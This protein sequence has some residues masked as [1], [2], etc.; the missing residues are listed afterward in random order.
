M[1]EPEAKRQ[2]VEMLRDDANELAQFVDRKGDV[3]LPRLVFKAIR[4]EIK[5]IRDVSDSLSM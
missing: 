3:D 5:R 2:A 4:N 1:T